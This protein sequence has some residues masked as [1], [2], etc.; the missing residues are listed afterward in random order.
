MGY[1]A[2]AFYKWGLWSASRPFTAIFIVAIVVSI[3]TVGFI[4]S[5]T[6]VSLSFYKLTLLG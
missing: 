2:N 6:T 1:L 3:G 4:N 5:Q